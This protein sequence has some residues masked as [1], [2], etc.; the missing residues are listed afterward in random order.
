MKNAYVIGHI[1]VKDQDKWNDYRN[2][3]AV[4]LEAWDAELIFRGKLCSILSGSHTHHN[5]VVIRFPDSK[6]IDNWYFSPEYQSLIV[7][8][9]EA[10][11]MELLSYE[12]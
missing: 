8:R 6:A 5:T 10:A 11:D 3:V 12:E 4:T 1:T 7:L 9:Q 2:K